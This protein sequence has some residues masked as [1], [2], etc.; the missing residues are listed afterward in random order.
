VVIEAVHAVIAQAAMRGPWRPEDLAGEAV[1]Q[2]DRLAL[3]QDLLGPWR[4]SICGAVQRIWHLCRDSGY[5]HRIY[6][7]R[8][9]GNAAS[10]SG[11]IDR[12]TLLTC[13]GGEKG[14]KGA[15]VFSF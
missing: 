8:R 11:S 6:P 12:R 7:E 15:K 3:D 4:R 5:S 9:R 14:Q 10:A 2:L 13:K 1:F